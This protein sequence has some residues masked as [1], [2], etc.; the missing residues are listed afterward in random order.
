MLGDS[1]F[2][3]LVF[4]AVRILEYAHRIAPS[5]RVYGDGTLGAIL[6]CAALLDDN[7]ERG[8]FKRVLASWDDLVTERFFNP[9]YF[10]EV[11]GLSAFPDVR[12]MAAWMPQVTV[13]DMLDARG[14]L[15][16]EDGV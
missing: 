5:V 12:T 10:F 3:M 15:L 16:K 2:A 1:L 14:Q 13:T 7:I 6:L 8:T 4:D 11:F 9:D